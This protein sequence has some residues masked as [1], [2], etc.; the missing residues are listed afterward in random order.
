VGEKEEAKP[1]AE[2]ELR[3]GK[4]KSGLKK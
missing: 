1:Q 4:K 2:N 3:G